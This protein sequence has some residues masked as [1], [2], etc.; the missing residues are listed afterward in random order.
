M[1]EY[2]SQQGGF[3]SSDDLERY[4]PEWVQPISTTY[5]GWTV[6]E[7]PPNSIGVAALSML[8][9]MERFPVSEYG[10][11]SVRALHLM[12]EAKK[13]AYAYN[14]FGTGLVVPGAGFPLHDRGALFDFEPER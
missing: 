1:V 5:R 13:L 8:N 6:W 4:Q 12:I 3:L 7:L 14:E 9:I 2:S 11:N 10:Q